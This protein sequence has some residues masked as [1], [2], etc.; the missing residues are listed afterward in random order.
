MSEIVDI[1]NCAKSYLMNARECYDR[2]DYQ[3][4]LMY[5]DAAKDEIELL[6]KYAAEEKETTQ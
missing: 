6:E 3:Q 4:A 5:L 1:E 2:R